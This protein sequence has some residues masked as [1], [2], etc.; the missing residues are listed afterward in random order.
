MKKILFIFFVFSFLILVWCSNDDTTIETQED[1]INQAYEANDDAL[2]PEE[3]LARMDQEE[4]SSTWPLLVKIISPEEA[5]FTPGQARFYKAE[6][7]WNA[8]NAR[9]QCHWKFYLNEY[10][11]ETLYQQMDGTCG[12]GWCG[13]TSTFIESR[14]DLRV[15]L[16]VNTT[17][18]Q[19]EILQTWSDEKNFRVQ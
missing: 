5:I 10:D 6:V 14:G 9:C 2:T 7:Q 11:E 8:E 13:F 15:H 12:G 17:N 3:V 16:D 1:N 18:Y 4:W 19:W